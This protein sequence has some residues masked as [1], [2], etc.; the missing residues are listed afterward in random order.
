MRPSR[1]LRCLAEKIPA[2]QHLQIAQPSMMIVKWKRHGAIHMA[3]WHTC[4]NPGPLGQSIEVLLPISKPKHSENCFQHRAACRATMEGIPQGCPRL[5]A[6]VLRVWAALRTGYHPP[7]DACHLAA[8]AAAQLHR[9][10]PQGM[11]GVRPW[12]VHHLQSRDPGRGAPL[13]QGMPAGYG[14]TDS[15]P[16]TPSPELQS[17]KSS[18]VHYLRSMEIESLSQAKAKLIRALHDRK[19]REAEGCFLVEGR[20]MVAEALESGWVLR[21]WVATEAYWDAL[22]VAE[23]KRLSSSPV[24]GYFCSERE[25]GQLSALNSPEGILAVV[26]MPLAPA[27]LRCNEMQVGPSGAA[28]F[29]D[30]V[31][32]PGN[33]G[34][35]MRIADWYGFGT[36]VCKEGTADCFNPK[37]LRASMGSV[38]RVNMWYVKEFDAAV[39][40]HAG[41][42][43]V[44]AMAGA[45]P[46]GPEFLGRRYLLLG[47]ESNGIS[48]ALL[49]VPDLNVVTIPRFGGAE[50]LNVAVSAGILAHAWRSGQ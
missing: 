15:T 7:L 40:A 33:L 13:G 38:F 44:A 46:A 17:G 42:V 2:I 29:L 43:N 8:R 32:D 39:A 6:D 28:F 5:F 22:E 4:Q 18:L 12:M 48:P 3:A 41:Q 25:M 14:A 30:A 31:Q 19:G 9:T 20:K 34:T 24:K 21:W 36:I 1:V 37:V 45:A 49:A 35:L 50:S 47:N 16:N 10:V 23:R 26:E 11:D 27:Y